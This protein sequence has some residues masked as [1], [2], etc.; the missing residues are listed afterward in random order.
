MIILIAILI[1]TLRHYLLDPLRQFIRIL[2]DSS[3]NKSYQRLPSERKDELGQIAR[4]YNRL[5]SE[6][7]DGYKNLESKVEQRTSALAKAKQAAEVARQAAEIANLRKSEYLTDISHEIRTPLNGVV[8]SLELLKLSSLNQEQK[9][10]AST[11]E[12]C[13]DSLLTLVN[14]ILDI[15]R[16]EAGEMILTLRQFSPLLLAKQALKIV[17]PRALSKGLELT[18]TASSEIPATILCDGQR[19]KQ[20][21]INL[22]ANA[23]KFTPGERFACS[24]TSNNRSLALPLKIR[25][26][27]LPGRISKGSSSHFTKPAINNPEAA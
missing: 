7:E 3:R 26:S 21:L 22:L 24:W 8:G 14:N 25:G 19:I 15:S 16:I 4:A 5:I 10:M 23:V 1:L 20:I 9:E 27:G 2:H 11:A 13:A 17:E 12:Q 18:I 6:V